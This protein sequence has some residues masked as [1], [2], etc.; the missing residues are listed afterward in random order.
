MIV[1]TDE[2]E[3]LSS[4]LRRRFGNGVRV[5]TLTV[6]SVGG[7]NKTY[8]FDLVEG[9]S[10]RRL[11][12]RTETYSA[13]DSP[14]LSPSDQ[15]ALMTEVFRRGFPVPEPVFEYD[16]AD[17]MG[18]GFVTAFVDGTTLPKAVIQSPELAVAR[19][20][21][22]SQCG[23]LLTAL[24]RVPLGGIE[25]L[26]ARSDS[27]D[28]V[29][30]QRDRYDGYGVLRPAIELGLRWLERNRPS[31]R[32][33]VLIHGDFRVGNLMLSE[34]GV[35]AVLDWE[36]SHLGSP[37]EDI[38]WLCTR[39]WR[40]GQPD[41]TVGGIA[42]LSDLLAAYEMPDGSRL[43]EEEVRYWMIFGLVRWAVLNV[44]Q[45]RGHL[46]GQRRSVVFAACGRNAS[47]IEYDL[48]MTLKGTY[49]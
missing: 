42:P 38:G 7:S 45:G 6:P 31:V 8:V 15:F 2:L 26:R 43:N 39:S 36:C 27:I 24:H 29:A 23:E 13:A 9:M 40:F 28:P 22:A 3:L 41:L 18:Q 12:S 30:A 16:E 33:Q 46:D 4:A 37:A 14:F 11:V 44:M 17:R 10:R 48:L 25:F 20:G 21:F 32:P 49:A 19:K 5:E 1:S 34:Q 47:L 35:V